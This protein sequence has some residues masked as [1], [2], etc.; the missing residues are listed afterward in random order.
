M[1]KF[2]VIIEVAARKDI[3]AHYL[4]LKRR[5]S[6]AAVRWFNGISDKIQELETLPNLNGIA[7]ESDAF[8]LTIRHA[9]YGRRPHR[10]RIL[11]TVVRDRVHVLHVRHGA[12]NV[13]PP[14]EM[15]F[16]QG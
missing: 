7:P 2:R 3:E 1:K 9:L 15:G 10:Y 11:F 8:P 13:L 4:Y 5:S 14:E 12:Q 16:S 6:S